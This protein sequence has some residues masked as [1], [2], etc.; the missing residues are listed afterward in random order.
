MGH[1]SSSLTI[2]PAL[3]RMSLGKRRRDVVPRGAHAKWLPS[4]D[5]RDPLEILEETNQGR[6]PEPIS[7]RYGR[8]LAGPFQFLRGS[9]ALMAEDLASTPTSGLRVQACGDCHLLNFGLLASP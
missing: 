4:F 6:V 2:S 7:I 9:A 3:R 5:R 1:P 8:M